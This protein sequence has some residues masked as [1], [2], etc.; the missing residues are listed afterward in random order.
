MGEANAR[1]DGYLSGA[2]ALA[3]AEGA[4]SDAH[5]SPGGVAVAFS[6]G[7][8]TS[9]RALPLGIALVS[10][11]ALGG[12]SS[13]TA[14]GGVA[15]AQNAG[16]N[17]PDETFGRGAKTVCTALH[18][19]A[20][21]SNEGEHSSSCKSVLFIFQQSQEGDGPVV[22]AI[23]N[24]L[25]IGF[26]GLVNATA[27]KLLTDVIGMMQGSAIF[28]DVLGLKLVPEFQSDLIWIEMGPK[29]PKVGTGLGDWLGRLT[30]QTRSS[31]TEAVAATA[32]LDATT[33]P[34]DVAAKSGELT[35]VIAPVEP[36]AK[37]EAP[38][39]DPT[40]SARTNAPTPQV[41]AT[42][43]PEVDAS[44]PA[45]EEPAVQEPAVQEP[46]VQEP[47]VQEPVV[48]ESAAQAPASAEPVESATS[49][50]TSASDDLAP[51]LS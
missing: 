2:L 7:G 40:P 49:V 41:P 28:G 43:A 23:K 26:N 20:S 47:V 11:V 45:A 31:A 39:V 9:A 21:V 22:Y 24:P 30:G 16:F 15:L 1:A 51:A 42:P 48:Q 38:V 12:S 29:G 13:A 8:D 25:D 6:F 5:A 18:A 14:L 32:L 35:P 34:S 36:A 27:A 19:E 17:D 4:V 37:A 10:D 46:V 50:T 44:T 33:T 3:F